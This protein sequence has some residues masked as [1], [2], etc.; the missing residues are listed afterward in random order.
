MSKKI[1]NKI[2]NKMSNNKKSNVVNIIVIIYSII[3]IYL[4]ISN[5]GINMKQF[6]NYE[7]FKN[8]K[9]VFIVTSMLGRNFANRIKNEMVILNPNINISVKN[10][11]ELVKWC[12]GEPQNPD[13]VLVR[14][15][16]PLHTEWI[17][18][19]EKMENKG[20]PV[21][22]PTK[23]L[24]LTSNKLKSSL[25]LM[26]KNIPHPY[27]AEGKQNDE[28]T[29]KT[30]KQLFLK[31]DTLILKPFTSSSQGAYVQKINKNMSDKEIKSKIKVIPTSPFVIQEYI[32]YVALYRVIVINNKALPLSYKDVP[33]KNKWKVSVCLNP[34]MT[35]VSNPPKELLETGELVQRAIFNGGVH[36]IDLFETKNN[37]N[38]YV[39]SEI[40]TSCSLLLHEKMAKAAN[41][42]H[43]NIAHHIGKYYLSLL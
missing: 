36:F 34:N 31:Y 32:D 23:I 15:A 22:N 24:Q 16:T 42:T 27:S 9:N 21:I 20:I 5:I 17:K 29:L 38:K 1:S 7:G 6:H 41:H 3:L 25:H 28:A 12:K 18:C 13:L 11:K 33:T 10:V 40:N 8:N 43:H 2:S 26:N 35:F 19:L 4:I 30:I 39:V 14:S 37:K